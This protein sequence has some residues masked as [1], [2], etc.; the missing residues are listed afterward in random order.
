MKHHCRLYADD[1]ICKVCVKQFWT[2]DRLVV[3]Y[4]RP[5]KPPSKRYLRLLQTVP[6][7]TEQG[8]Q[9]L[10]AQHREQVKSKS[11]DPVIDKLPAVVLQGPR[12]KL[13]AL[14]AIDVGGNDGSHMSLQDASALDPVLLADLIQVVALHDAS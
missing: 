9:L 14:T 12:V 6:P 10:D 2:R 3:H 5:G 4:R 1:T 13:Q 7:L 11:T 8:A